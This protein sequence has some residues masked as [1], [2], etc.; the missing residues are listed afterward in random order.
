LGQRIFQQPFSWKSLG[1]DMQA[2]RLPAGELADVDGNLGERRET[3]SVFNGSSPDIRLLD[4]QEEELEAVSEWLAAYPLVTGTVRHADD[5]LK[6]AGLQPR[7]HSRMG[8]GHQA[9]ILI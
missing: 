7:S 1:V 9:S 5:K 2:D 8:H 6:R 3:V 4:A